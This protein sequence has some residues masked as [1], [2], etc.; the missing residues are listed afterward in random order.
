MN[1]VFALIF[2]LMAYSADGDENFA[3][4]HPCK[5][6]KEKFCG[7]VEKGKG[8]IIK[9]LMDHEGE[10]SAECKAKISERKAAREERKGR[11]K[12]K[13][14]AMFDSCRDDVKKVCGE[15]KAGE[16]RIMECLR[17]KE[18]ELSADC[19]AN[20]PIGRSNRD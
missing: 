14:K 6:D 5:S 2:G 16:G 8:R 1:L 15:I 4:K 12:E 9:C 10:V 20:L 18:A 17:A 19:K 11:R 7:T 3:G 13:R